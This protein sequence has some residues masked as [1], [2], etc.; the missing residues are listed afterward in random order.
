MRVSDITISGTCVH[1]YMQALANTRPKYCRSVSK[2][3][4]WKHFRGQNY[5]H[6][7]VIVYFSKIVVN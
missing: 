5:S 7:I 4:E 1:V 6:G 3:Q 2:C